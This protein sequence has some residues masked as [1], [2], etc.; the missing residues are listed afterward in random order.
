MKKF[1]LILSGCGVYDGAEIH[2][3][4]ATMIAVKKAGA[5]Y[6]VFA[7][8][9][10]QCHVI[11]HLT[12]EVMEE[13]RNVLVESARIARGRIKGLAEFDPN[14]FDAVIFPGGFGAAKNLSDYAFK[15]S[16][17]TVVPEVE[18]AIKAIIEA[19]KPLGAECIAP[20][21]MARVLKGAT[22][23]IGSDK[24]TSEDIEKM[25]GHHIVAEHNG[26]IY[27]PEFKLYTTP[28]YMAAENILEVYESAEALVN[29]MIRG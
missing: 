21:V 15:G 25:G 20:A 17:C 19:G 29:A 1:A 22:V 28:C 6:Q 13:Q 2:E 5:D 24:A 11:N 7:P 8:D 9:V 3:S 18:T 4:V 27:D 10:E 12:G 23:T 14:D 26:V 16:D